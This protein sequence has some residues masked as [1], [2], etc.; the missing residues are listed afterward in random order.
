M[1]ESILA[2]TGLAEVIWTALIPNLSSLPPVTDL[3]ESVTLIKTSYP[4]LIKLSKLWY[5][6]LPKR[7]PLLDKLVRDGVIYAMVFSGDKIRIAE[8]EL[9]ALEL[10]VNEMGIYFVKHLKVFPMFNTSNCQHV[11]PLISSILANPVGFNHPPQLLLALRVLE[12][13]MRTCWPRIGHH[14]VEILRGITLCWRYI[15]GK[16][17]SDLGP[18]RESLKMA[19]EILVAASPETKVDIAAITSIDSYY[20]ELYQTPDISRPERDSSTSSLVDPPRT[21]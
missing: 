13:I 17:S 6:S 19:T 3:Q 2:K 21:N 4:A 9:E 14:H 1:D 8:V 10:L 11:I 16:E 5:A 12:T 20:A 7:V 18:V 15:R